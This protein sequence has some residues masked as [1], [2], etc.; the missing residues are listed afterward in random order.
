[1]NS[2]NVNITVSEHADGFAERCNEVFDR[3]T[4]D[5]HITDSIDVPAPVPYEPDTI[6][7][8]LYAKNWIDVAQWHME[9]LIRDPNID[10][11]EGMKLKHRIDASNQDRTDRVEDLDTYFRDLYKRV[12]PLPDAQINTESPAWALDRLSILAVK[13]YHMLAETER[14]DAS[15]EHIARCRAKLNVLLEQ[16]EDLSKAINTLLDDIAGGRKYMKVYR[17]MKMYNDADTNP[18]LYA[19][20]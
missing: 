20:K 13:I 16:R 14:A 18:V 6:E 3:A 5:Y 8:L 2:D 9:D 12:T 11:A 19:K 7:A 4:V 15:P 10:P 1:M 17:Q